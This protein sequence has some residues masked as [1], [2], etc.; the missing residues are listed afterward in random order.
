MPVS[1]ACCGLLLALSVR[2]RVAVRVPVPLGLNSRPIVHDFV[3]ATPAE[4]PLKLYAKSAALV[5]VMDMVT[6]P[7]AEVP[8]F[9]RV[10]TFWPPVLPTATLP[11]VMDDGEAVAPP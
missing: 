7:I 9:V 3:D 4:Q 5:P 8:L 2:F 6:A 11:Q 10:A 1:A